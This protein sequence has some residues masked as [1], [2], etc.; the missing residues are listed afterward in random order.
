MSAT[1]EETARHIAALTQ[2]EDDILLVGQ[3]IDAR[4]KELAASNNLRMLLREGELF[5]VEPFTTGTVSATRDS[6]TISGVG[7][8]WTTGLVGRHIR[9]KSSWYAIAVVVSGT[10][11]ELETPY[12]ED[13]LSGSGYHI[14]QRRHRLAPDVRKLGVFTHMRLRRQLHVVHKQGLDITIPSRFSVN[15]VPSWVAEVEADVDGVKRVEIYPF[16]NQTEII[17]YVY[18]R[19]PPTLKFND[20]LPDFID[21]EAFREGVMVDVLRHKMHKAMEMGQVEQAALW[22]NEFRAQETRW[23]R[24]HRTRV[25]GQEQ[26]SDDQEFILTREGAHPSGGQDRLINDAYSEIWY[27]RG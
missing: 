10:S 3:W 18:W 9:V 6:K 12:A 23:L 7:T 21:I 15:S 1:V 26:G 14:V 25:M 8:G 2:T 24:E 13:T 22:R 20:V 5:M 27:G 11:L 16:S 17:H 4:W 19:V